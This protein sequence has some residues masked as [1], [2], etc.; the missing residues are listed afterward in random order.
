MNGASSS[1]F[2]TCVLV[3]EANGSEWGWLGG[4]IGGILG[5]V[6]GIGGGGP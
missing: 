1:L 6:L 3:A 5:A 4:I 2:F